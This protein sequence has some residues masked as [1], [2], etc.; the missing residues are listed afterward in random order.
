[1]ELDTPGELPALSRRVLPPVLQLISTMHSLGQSAPP[2]SV[3]GLV[4]A[5]A[6]PTQLS[7]G[8]PAGGGEVF[9]LTPMES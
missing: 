2:Q 6:G 9:D 5:C 8:G 4:L 7:R 3:V 1:M